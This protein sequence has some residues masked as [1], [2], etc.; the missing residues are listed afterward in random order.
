M[1]CIYFLGLNFDVWALQY[2]SFIKLFLFN[3]IFKRFKKKTEFKE[4]LVYL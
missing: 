3:I 2:F 4:P 1:W